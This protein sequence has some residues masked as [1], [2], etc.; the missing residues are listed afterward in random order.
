MKRAIT[1]KTNGKKC[2]FFVDVDAVPG[3]EGLE[4]NN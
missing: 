4:C 3:M 1:N 2:A